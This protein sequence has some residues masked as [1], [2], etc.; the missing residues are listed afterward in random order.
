M[1]AAM[2]VLDT[3]VISEAMKPMAVR[4]PEVVAWLRAQPADELFATTPTFGEILAGA[5]SA[6]DERKRAALVKA[7][8]HIF[9]TVFAERILA[10]DEV[11]AHS[12]AEIV[13]S[14]IRRGRPISAIDGQIAAIARSRGMAVATRDTDFRETGVTLI[15]PWEM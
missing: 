6:R 11:A 5:L 4:S 10:F 9:A 12:Y 3:N 13:A 14:G 7:A 2:I 1:P 8:R 15:N